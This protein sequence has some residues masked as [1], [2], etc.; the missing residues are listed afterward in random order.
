MGSLFARAA[1]PCLLEK[2]SLFFVCQEFGLKL[3]NSLV[4]QPGTC[5]NMANSNPVPIYFPL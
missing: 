1:F 3:L 5:T 4:C 2:N